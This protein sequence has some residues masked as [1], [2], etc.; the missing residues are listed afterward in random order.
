MGQRGCGSCRCLGDAADVA[1]SPGR[2]HLGSMWSCCSQTQGC[3]GSYLL[4]G[5][6]LVWRDLCQCGL[7]ACEAGAAPRVGGEL[8]GQQYLLVPALQ[9]VEG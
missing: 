7:G 6:L 1:S 3:A 4:L 2:Q 8:E 9:L 5:S